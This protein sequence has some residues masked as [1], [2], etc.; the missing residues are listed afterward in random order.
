MTLAIE[1]TSPPPSIEFERASLSAASP[2]NIFQE[3][4]RASRQLTW[5]FVGDS[6]TNSNHA[7]ADWSTMPESLAAHIREALGRS[8]D[9][10]I[11]NTSSGQQIKRLVEEFNV[12]AVTFRPDVLVIQISSSESTRGL[13]RLGNFE[14]RL[15]LLVQ[16]AMQEGMLPIL[17]T[18]PMGHQTASDESL[19]EL[20]YVE[21]IR[22]MAAEFDLP[23]VDHW[24]HWHWVASDIGGTDRW[25]D[26][27]S[28]FPNQAGHDQMTRRAIEDLWLV[29]DA[30][31]ST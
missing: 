15:M 4:L 2:L 31:H 10:L 27:E 3:I 29:T 11:D 21:A 8:R 6:H 19:D 28:H 17:C 12:R 30:T 25:F 7:A 24:A 26:P 13:G 16:Q 22:A 9:T 18:P 1:A 5:V 20:V 23:L 14:R